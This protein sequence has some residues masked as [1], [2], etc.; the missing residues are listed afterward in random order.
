[1][2]VSDAPAQAC[3]LLVCRSP[4]P[5]W[6]LLPGFLGVGRKRDVLYSRGLPGAQAGTCVYVLWVETGKGQV[7]HQA[8]VFDAVEPCG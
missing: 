1:M 4:V 8:I 3:H 6:A 5:P 2:D 7:R